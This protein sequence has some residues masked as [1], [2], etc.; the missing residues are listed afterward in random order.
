MLI[1]I[2]NYQFVHNDSGQKVFVIA[3]KKLKRP[4]DATEEEVTAFFRAER[5]TLKIM[6]EIAHANLIQAIATYEKGEAGAERCF[7]FPW[8][9]GGNLRQ[10]WMHRSPDSQDV[11][12]WAWGQIRGLTEGLDKLHKKDTRHGD[13][14][15]ENILIFKRGKN[16]GLGSLVIADVGIAKYH[17]FETSE[18]KVREVQTNT[19]FFTGQYE[20]P[21]IRLDQ[22]TAISRRY[23][24]WSLGCV[25]LEFI[26][27]LQHGK[28]GLK[29][30][31]EE[32]QLATSNEDRFWSPT[33]GR[34]RVLHPTAS[35]WIQNLLE[36]LKGRPELRA[37]RELLKLVKTHLLVAV[38]DQRKYIWDFW[39]KLQQIHQECS[40]DS[41]HIGERSDM[42]LT[43]RSES[44]ARII[45]DI[46]VSISRQVSSAEIFGSNSAN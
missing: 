2:V 41:S 34:G 21:E 43:E 12:H 24:S 4:E 1:Q 26:I 45:D 19:R 44:P 10:L 42:V 23:D 17:A 15:P 9:S 38:L 18:R 6:R 14:K 3:V 31:H 32:R 39:P 8:A 33:A 28:D 27:W 40:A 36:E 13:L 7:V 25:L 35:K 20:P 37:W 29:E 30:F 5:E 11:F 46:D 22:P 16:P